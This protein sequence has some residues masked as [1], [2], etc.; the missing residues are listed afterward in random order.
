VLSPF[1]DQIIT[2]FVKVPLSDLAPDSERPV[3][4]ELH[5]FGRTH[6]T[7]G[8]IRRVSLSRRAKLSEA[9]RHTVAAIV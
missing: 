7:P 1:F 4:L 8:P 5:H 9:V 2:A 6:V 3:D